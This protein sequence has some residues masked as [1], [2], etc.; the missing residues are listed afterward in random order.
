MR[1]TRTE[2]FRLSTLFAGIFLF[3]GGIVFALVYWTTSHALE[4]QVRVEIRRE[5]A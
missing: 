1:L 3:A 5:A 2:G 4:D